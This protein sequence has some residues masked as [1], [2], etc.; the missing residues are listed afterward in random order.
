MTAMVMQNLG[1][2]GVGGVGGRV[3]KMHS[4][5]CENDEQYLKK[6][7]CPGIARGMLKLR[8]HQY[9]TQSS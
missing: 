5:L 8:F 1:G 4:G 2:G 9:I 7:K 6:V 3:N